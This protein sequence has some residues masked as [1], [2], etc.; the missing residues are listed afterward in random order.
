MS[1]EKLSNSDNAYF[2]IDAVEI[3]NLCMICECVENNDDDYW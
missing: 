3:G 2:A 1:N